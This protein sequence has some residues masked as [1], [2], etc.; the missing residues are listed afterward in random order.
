LPRQSVTCPRGWG[1]PKA[2]FSWSLYVFYGGDVREA[3]LPWLFGQVG[4][5]E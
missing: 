2:P 3:D 1:F 4:L 5:I